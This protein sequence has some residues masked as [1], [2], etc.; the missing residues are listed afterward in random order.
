MRDNVHT[1]EVKLSFNYCEDT[2]EMQYK[3]S[4]SMQL[5]KLES[6]LPALLLT[7]LAFSHNCTQFY[8]VISLNLLEVL[9]WTEMLHLV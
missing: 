5:I 4:L 7:F 3:Q 8:D 6:A 2:E 1:E 9:M